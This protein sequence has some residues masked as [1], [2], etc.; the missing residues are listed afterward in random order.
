MLFDYVILASTGKR[1][2]KEC[3]KTPR[4]KTRAPHYHPKPVTTYPPV[5]PNCVP[6]NGFR[7]STSR[8]NALPSFKSET[9]HS[10]TSKIRPKSRTQRKKTKTKGNPATGSK[11]LRNSTPSRRSYHK[12]FQRLYCKIKARQDHIPA[13]RPALHAHMRVT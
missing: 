13:P 8:T 9:D 7:L 4:E 3:P 10:R 6:R 12:R 1:K 5:H 11:P 2:E